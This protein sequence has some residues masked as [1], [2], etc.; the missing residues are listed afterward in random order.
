MSYLHLCSFTGRLQTLFLLHPLF[1]QEVSKLEEQ[2]VYQPLESQGEAANCHQ[3][4]ACRILNQ[5]EG[6]DSKSSW[7]LVRAVRWTLVDPG[8]PYC[9]CIYLAC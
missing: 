5:V 8:A 1:L 7:L 2:A 4:S 3:D 6:I 9:T